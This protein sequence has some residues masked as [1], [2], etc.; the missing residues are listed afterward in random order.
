[1]E[2]CTYLRKYRLGGGYQGR[3]RQGIGGLISRME[4]CIYINCYYWIMFLI[5]CELLCLCNSENVFNKS[6]NT[7]W[8]YVICFPCINLHIPHVM[9]QQMRNTGDIHIALGNLKQMH[10]FSG[11]VS[12]HRCSGSTGLSVSV[13]AAED[14]PE[15]EEQCV[16]G[17]Q[18]LQCSLQGLTKV[19]VKVSA[20]GDLMKTWSQASLESRCNFI[21][22]LE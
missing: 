7:H 21:R 20:I 12:G 15:Q 10:S 17:H 5:V 8:R 18:G 14:S 11:L 3:G 4:Q 22:K 2:E 13:R 19:W 16:E 1:M 6:K 9:S